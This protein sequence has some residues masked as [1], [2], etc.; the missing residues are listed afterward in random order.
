M[1]QNYPPMGQKGKHLLLRYYSP[2]M[3]YGFMGIYSSQIPCCTFMTTEW[4]PANVLHPASLKKSP[5]AGSKKSL[6]NQA[7]KHSVTVPVKAHM[8]CS[9]HPQLNWK[10]WDD[11]EVLHKRCLVLL[12]L[13][14]SCFSQVQSSTG[15]PFMH[16]P[17]TISARGWV[18]QTSVPTAPLL[19]RPSLGW[20]PHTPQSRFPHPHQPVSLE[21]TS[22]KKFSLWSSAILMSL[23]R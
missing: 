2:L 18:E 9:P 17:V 3:D 21:H 15:F 22:E 23:P 16:W 12:I 5:K 10:V 13:S 8:S 20:S 14:H 7:G 4:S 19:L 6:H 1:Y 11:F